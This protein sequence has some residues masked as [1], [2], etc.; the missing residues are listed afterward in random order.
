MPQPH[1][2]RFPTAP[3]PTREGKLYCWVVLKCVLPPGGGWSIDTHQATPLVTCAL[4]MAMHRIPPPEQTV[5]GSDHGSQF[6][7]WA[8]TQSAKDSGLLPWM[9]TIGD[10][11]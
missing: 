11:L 3:S 2:D 9:G 6:T 1:L 10:A 5:I 8:F 4:G 7:S